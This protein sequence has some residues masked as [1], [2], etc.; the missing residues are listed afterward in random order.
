VGD[1]LAAVVDV[2]QGYGDDVHVVVGIDAA[3]YGQA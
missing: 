2:L 1:L 3:G